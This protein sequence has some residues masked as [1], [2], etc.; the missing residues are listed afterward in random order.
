MGAYQNDIAGVS[1]LFWQ[2]LQKAPAENTWI[3]VLTSAHE[4]ILNQIHS[5]M[6]KLSF[7][8]LDRPKCLMS[9]IRVVLLDAVVRWKQLHGDFTA[10]LWDGFAFGTYGNYSLSK[11]LDPHLRDQ[12]WP[13]S[14]MAANVWIEST[15]GWFDK[16]TQD[17]FEA[18]VKEAPEAHQIENE[19]EATRLHHQDEIGMFVPYE[20][21]RRKVFGLV[22]FINQTITLRDRLHAYQND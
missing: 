15:R 8:A 19:A 1:G 17:L 14:L 16:H 2:L 6:A 4:R 21:L 10:L 11:D 3:W 9:H 13:E 12:T 22:Y 5:Y 7:L 20:Y 18:T